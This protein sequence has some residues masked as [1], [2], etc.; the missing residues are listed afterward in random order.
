[1]KRII[2]MLLNMVW[3]MLI[4]FILLVG[5]VF[6]NEKRFYTVH[7]FGEGNEVYE[8]TLSVTKEVAEILIGMTLFLTVIFMVMF[9]T[10]F[11]WNIVYSL[12][13]KDE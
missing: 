4:S 9:V 2:N 11:V 12:K 8:T 3:P 10:G 1:M 6:I 5:E 13:H 7:R